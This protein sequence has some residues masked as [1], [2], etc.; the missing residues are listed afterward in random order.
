[1]RHTLCDGVVDVR[2]VIDQRV[3]MRFDLGF[4]FSTEPDSRLG[5]ASQA[6]VAVQD[7]RMEKDFYNPFGVRLS[8]QPPMAQ[9]TL[10][11]SKRVCEFRAYGAWI[12]WGL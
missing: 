1:M 8:R 12:S 2:E 9:Q 7:G 4:S 11:G 5:K 6:T 3:E 10:L